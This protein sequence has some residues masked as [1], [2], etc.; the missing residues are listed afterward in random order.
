MQKALTNK[1]TRT[2]GSLFVSIIALM[3]MG[4]TPPARLPGQLQKEAI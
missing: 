3:G 4:K 2:S 1:D